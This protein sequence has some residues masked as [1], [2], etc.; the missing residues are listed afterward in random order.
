MKLI[1]SLSF[2][3]IAFSSFAQRGKIEN[4]VPVSPE[5]VVTKI[6]QINVITY[7]VKGEPNKR[8]YGINENELFQ[9]FGK[10]NFGTVGNDT[11]FSKDNLLAICFVA[12]QYLVQE[13]QKLI[14]TQ[15]KLQLQL[16]TSEESS[17]GTLKETDMMR[18]ELDD[19]RMKL[20]MLEENMHEIQRRISE[21]QD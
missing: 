20:K 12:V 8:Y 16:D 11:S 3:I 1:L 7:S 19:M 2:L 17:E 14:E 5:S 15:K 9:L 10:D 18:N 13:N 6:D 21:K 4:P